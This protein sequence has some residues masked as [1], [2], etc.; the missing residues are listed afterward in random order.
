MVLQAEETNGEIM[1][2][3]LVLLS[4]G[5]SPPV[6]SCRSG[7]S[8][9]YVAVRG[10][11]FQSRASPQ[12]QVAICRVNPRNILSP[13]LCQ[14]A[15]LIVQLSLTRRA[16]VDGTF[17]A[18]RVIKLKPQSHRCEE[19]A[20]AATSAV[21]ARENAMVTELIAAGTFYCVTS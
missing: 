6:S 16:L 18:M 13:A 10:R 11:S 8:N 20:R 9:E 17:R 4:P 12:A 2:T 1:R 21:N 15:H 14:N 3:I 7:G 5:Y 19:C